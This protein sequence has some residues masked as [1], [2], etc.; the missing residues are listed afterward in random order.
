MG[1]VD[2]IKCPKSIPQQEFS[3]ARVGH[4]RQGLGLETGANI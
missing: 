2:L 4:H 3:L 1:L